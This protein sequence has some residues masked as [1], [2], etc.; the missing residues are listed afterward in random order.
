MTEKEKIE[1]CAYK[2]FVSFY[3]NKQGLSKRDCEKAFLCKSYKDEY[4]N[5]AKL[6]IKEYNN[7]S[8]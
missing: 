8:K 7:L 4:I 6:C 2:L 1:K 3:H 5:I